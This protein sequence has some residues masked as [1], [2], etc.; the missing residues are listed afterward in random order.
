MK[1]ISKK[2]YGFLF[3]VAI[4]FGVCANIFQSIE[5]VEWGLLFLCCAVSIF[6]FDK[7]YEKIVLFLFL[8]SVFTFQVVKLLLGFFMNESDWNFGMNN[9]DTLIVQNIIFLTILCLVL[10]FTFDSKYKIKIKTQKKPLLTKVVDEKFNIVK[11]QNIS[12]IIYLISLTITIIFNFKKAVYA[13]SNG[14]LSLYTSFSQSAFAS[15][16]QLIYTAAFFIC[17]AAYPSKKRMRFYLITGSLLPILSLIQGTRGGFVCY[18]FFLFFYLYEYEDILH[19]RITNIKRKK[20]FYFWCCIGVIATLFIVPFLYSYGHTRSNQ[21]YIV[22]TSLLDGIKNF[23]FEQSNSM[24]LIKYAVIYKGELPQQF[25]SLGDFADRFMGTVYPS[26]SVDKAM[27]SHSFGDAISYRVASI[28]YLRGVGLGSSYLAEVYYDFGYAGILIV[29][30]CLGIF[31]HRSMCW[32]KSGVVKNAV[33]FFV[34][35]YILL[36]PRSA[37]V[38]PI[39]NLLSSSVVVTFIFVFFFSYKRKIK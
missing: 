35:Y 8:V 27:L 22:S 36:I 17:M 25:Y 39:N 29:N 37:L 21:E 38:Y 28:G 16:F 2:V 20:K 24:Q 32:E 9:R 13:L 31:F 12:L 18:V 6:C 7:F 14:Y 10:G 23:L 1:N 30:F 26:Q 34:F 19:L 5:T 4:V 15:R 33:F 11:I 3:M